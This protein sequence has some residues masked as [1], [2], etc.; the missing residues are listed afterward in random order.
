MVRRKNISGRKGKSL[1]RVDRIKKSGA[2]GRKIGTVEA[3]SRKSA[4]EFGFERGVRNVRVTPIVLEK[5]KKRKGDT[6]KVFLR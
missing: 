3:S 4:A 2:T 1:F 6:R 5:A